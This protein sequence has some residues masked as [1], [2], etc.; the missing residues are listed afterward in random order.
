MG[1]WLDSVCYELLC[2]MILLYLS[3]DLG[4]SVVLQQI[5]QKI[6]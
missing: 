1:E 5:L 6:A 2:A 4:V 3:E